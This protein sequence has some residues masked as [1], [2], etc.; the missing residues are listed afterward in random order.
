MAIPEKPYE[1]F[2]SEKAL[3]NKR[4]AEVAHA[5]KAA[6]EAAG[7]TAQEVLLRDVTS[8]LTP[9]KVQ[10]Y[11]DTATI[12]G[13]QILDKGFTGPQAL[14]QVGALLHFMEEKGVPTKELGAA[15]SESATPNPERPQS[16]RVIITNEGLR[17]LSHILEQEASKTRGSVLG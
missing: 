2:G 14:A 17:S 11:F 15:Y 3:M 1:A 8:G 5:A 10:N 7:P 9:L 16:G 12:Y 13:A 6:F 4:S